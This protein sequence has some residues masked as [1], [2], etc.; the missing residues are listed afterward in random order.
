MLVNWNR[1]S[2]KTFESH[3]RPTIW[4]KRKRKHFCPCC[5]LGC[6]QPLYISIFILHPL[7]LCW[8]LMLS[9]LRFIRSPVHVGNQSN[10]KFW[11]LFLHLVST[12]CRGVFLQLYDLLLHISSCFMF[13]IYFFCCSASVS[14]YRLIFMY[15]NFQ[16]NRQWHPMS[17]RSSFQCIFHAHSL[18]YDYLQLFWHFHCIRFFFFQFASV[19]PFFIT[20]HPILQL[21]LSYQNIY[22]F[23]LEYFSVFG[24]LIFIGWFVCSSIW[25]YHIWMTCVLDRMYSLLSRRVKKRGQWRKETHTSEFCW[26]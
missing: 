24:N 19:L 11:I 9:A 10:R 22:N 13:H 26:Q 3:S 21:L 20:F 12:F 25:W 2:G 16:S 18:F 6:R 17:T 14:I 4:P 23:L 15:F 7:A 1:N 8:T 5:R